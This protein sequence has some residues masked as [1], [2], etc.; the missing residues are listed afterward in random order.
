MTSGNL[1]A[2][3]VKKIRELLTHA[4]PA[5]QRQG[6]ELARAAGDW[7]RPPLTGDTR[8]LARRL[9]GGVPFRE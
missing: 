1:A 7:T 9:L 8:A 3:D 4:D 5:F 2:D 6:V